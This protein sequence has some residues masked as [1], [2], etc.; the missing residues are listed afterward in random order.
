MAKST[1]VSR[2]VQSV[3]NAVSKAST[4]LSDKEYVQF[5]EE[6]LADAEGWKMDLNEREKEEED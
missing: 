3:R 1:K 2:A 5:F 6:L 4:G